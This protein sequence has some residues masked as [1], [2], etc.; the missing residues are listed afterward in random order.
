MSDV[1][2]KMNQAKTHAKMS[3]KQIWW[4]NLMGNCPGKGTS[5][6]FE[7]TVTY[8]HLDKVSEMEVYINI[9]FFQREQKI[10][11]YFSIKNTL[12]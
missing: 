10:K 6:N 8:R 2:Y 11:N 9:L 1:P 5:D 7:A 12:L 3:G 4:I